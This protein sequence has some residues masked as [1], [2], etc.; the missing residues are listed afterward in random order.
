MGIGPQL[1]HSTAQLRTP[2]LFIGRCRLIEPP[3]VGPPKATLLW[4]RDIFERI[5][6][7]VMMAMIGDPTDRRA[8]AIENGPENQE[9]LDE[10]V[11]LESAMREQAMI[12]NGYAETSESREEKRNADNPGIRQREKK[13]A[14]YSQEVNQRKIEENCAF[15]WGGFPKRPLPGPSLLRDG[16]A[17]FESQSN[18]VEAL[19][20]NLKINLQ[21][22]AAE[23]PS[24]VLAYGHYGRQPIPSRSRKTGL[25]V[26]DWHWQ[27][28]RDGALTSKYR[29]HPDTAPAGIRMLRS[30]SSPYIR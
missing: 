13:Q 21:P 14:D 19:M 3:Q 23:I 20:L 6:V 7:G 30:R 4:A 28:I 29:A 1:V 12:T 27:P 25:W 8:A 11:E 16:I 26:D 17:H 9:V 24:P 2:L 22:F 5:R 15:A 10:L 18:L